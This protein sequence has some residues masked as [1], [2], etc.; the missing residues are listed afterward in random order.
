MAISLQNA[1]ESQDVRYVPL[2][3]SASVLPYCTLTHKV[4]HPESREII[5]SS[6]GIS[7]AL[8]QSRVTA[9]SLVMDRPAIA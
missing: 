8:I 3:V 4:E 5:T 9:C 7:D 2:H 1:R 6:W